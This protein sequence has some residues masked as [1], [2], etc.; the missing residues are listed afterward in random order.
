MRWAA[1]KNGIEGLQNPLYLAEG[2]MGCGMCK[3][4]IPTDE[5]H[6][7]CFAQKDARDDANSH[8]GRTRAA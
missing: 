3:H 2:I 5:V 6:E 7:D 8:T 1:N 4:N